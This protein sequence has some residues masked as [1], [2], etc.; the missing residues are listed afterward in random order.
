MRRIP[1]LCL[2][3]SLLVVG[4]ASSSDE[5]TTFVA[6]ENL[7]EMVIPV[8]DIGESEIPVPLDGKLNIY[9]ESPVFEEGLEDAWDQTLVSP[10]A[11][12][13]HGG[14]Y[15]MFYNGFAIGGGS[16][17]G[18]IGYA[19]SAN[20]T[21]WY[22]MADMPIL[23]W[24]DALG[25]DYWVRASSALLEN[26]GTWVLYLSSFSHG[27]T[28]ALPMI[29]RAT[30]PVP[31]GPWTF[32]DIPVL[33]PGETGEWDY[34]GV[35]DPIVLKTETGYLMYYLNAHFDD[36]RGITAI[37]LATS[38]NGVNWTKYNDPSTEERF[39][40]SDPIFVYVGE[41]SYNFIQAHVV[42]QDTDGF[43]MLYG[44]GR[45]TT[46]DMHYL[47]SLDGIVWTAPVDEPVFSVDD[48]AFLGDYTAPKVLYFD[49]QYLVYLY[50]SGG[51]QSFGDIYL[52]TVTE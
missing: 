20:G 14:L 46:N 33:E 12:V 11:V 43:S 23:N 27:V 1:Y 45:N 3:V 21:E 30:A 7:E 51:S 24:D 40:M 22:R 36:R 13:Y 10:G 19:I 31:N 35:E 25:D 38:E 32:D 26:D 37:G 47:T 42:W 48:V 16:A 41:I 28:E 9:G 34:Y 5:P 8:A 29:Y 17:N 39:S 4:C 18:G 49:G 44:V 2:V 50:G 15:H 52:A 6:S